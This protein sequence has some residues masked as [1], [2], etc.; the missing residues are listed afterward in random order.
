MDRENEMEGKDWSSTTRDSSFGIAKQYGCTDCNEKSTQL[1]PLRRSRFT[2]CEGRI[3]D[4][5]VCTEGEG[6]EGEDGAPPTCKSV[7]VCAHRWR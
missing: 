1:S 3:S 4:L 7:D 6:V 5:T 2:V